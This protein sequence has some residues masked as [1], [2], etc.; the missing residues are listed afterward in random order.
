MTESQEQKKLMKWIHGKL[1]EV[2]EVTYHVKNEGQRKGKT[3]GNDIAMGIRKGVP[4][5][6]IDHP[7]N[8]YHGLRIEMKR[9][10]GGRLSQPQR[11]W[12]ERL[13]SRGYLAV[14]CHGFEKAKKVI[15]D[16]LK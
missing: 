2:W 6:I 16:Y 15:E 1:P 9:A 11:K 8:G 14:C 10:D 4:D 13:N 12:L 3:I 7:S 5:I